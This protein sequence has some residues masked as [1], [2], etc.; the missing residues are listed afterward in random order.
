MGP[1]PSHFDGVPCELEPLRALATNAG[2]KLG[3]PAIAP[4][5]CNGV[6]YTDAPA[7]KMVSV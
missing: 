3:I 2:A 6:I 1:A 7:G 4:A 5:R